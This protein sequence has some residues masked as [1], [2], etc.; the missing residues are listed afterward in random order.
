MKAIMKNQFK[1]ISP[2]AFL[3]MADIKLTISANADNRVLSRL[4]DAFC[5]MAY[6]RGYRMSGMMIHLMNLR[7]NARDNAQ[8]A[9]YENRYFDLLR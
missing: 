7:D 4:A 8:S 3:T 5:A 1:R 2:S 9:E 6:E